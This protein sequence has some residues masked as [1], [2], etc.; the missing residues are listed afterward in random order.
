MLFLSECKLHLSFFDFFLLT[1]CIFILLARLHFPQTCSYVSP[2]YFL[3]SLLPQKKKKL[4]EMIF[5]CSLFF[6]GTVQKLDFKMKLVVCTQYRQRG[7]GL[8]QN[9]WSGCWLI[10]LIFIRSSGVVYKVGRGNGIFF[11]VTLLLWCFLFSG[12]SKTLFCSFVFQKKQ[13]SAPVITCQ[14]PLFNFLR[15]E[16]TIYYINLLKKIII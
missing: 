14:L 9:V 3:L 1:C 7:R 13:I 5:F 8:V 6:N 2:S 12:R 4:V 16:I 15:I 10:V 11:F